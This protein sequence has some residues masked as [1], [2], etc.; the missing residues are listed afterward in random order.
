MENTENTYTE[1]ALA[2]KI[3]LAKSRI[4]L[5]TKM[6]KPLMDS[7]IKAL[8]SGEYKQCTSALHQDESQGGGHCC[9]GVLCEV[10]GLFKHKSLSFPD[11]KYATS[12]EQLEAGNYSTSHLPEDFA[13][14]IGLE[15]AGNLGPETLEANWIE[16][17]LVE[18]NDSG[19]TFKQIAEVIEAVLLP[20]PVESTNQE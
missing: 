11:W 13:E 20:A 17:S 4:P 5:Q 7:W 3:A 10:A 12:K 1:S 8:R 18:L 14:K 6:P 19:A 15:K 9:L 2:A 16:V